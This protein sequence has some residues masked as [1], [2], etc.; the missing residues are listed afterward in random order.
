MKF[1]INKPTFNYEKASPKHSCELQIYVVDF[2]HLMFEISSHK[3][4][5]T[6]HHDTY[7]HDSSINIP[8]GNYFHLNSNGKINFLQ[9][10]Y[11]KKY[12]GTCWHWKRSMKYL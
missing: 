3:G 10:F 1:S 4:T 11:I 5:N 12:S 9:F 7:G 6:F 2:R 8:H